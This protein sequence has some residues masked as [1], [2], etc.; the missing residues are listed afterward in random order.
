MKN[1]FLITVTTV[2]VTIFLWI[3]YLN[4]F[5]SKNVNYRFFERKYNNTT[6][7][8]TLLKLNK[9]MSKLNYLDNVPSNDSI[10]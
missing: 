9:K 2:F 7:V 3:L 10:I 8:L 5:D 4:F 6:K 1:K